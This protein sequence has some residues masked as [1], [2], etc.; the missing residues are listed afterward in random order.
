MTDPK[1]EHNSTDPAL[2]DTVADEEVAAP[3]DED[4]PSL[5]R[6]EASEAGPIQGAYPPIP[7]FGHSVERAVPRPPPPWDDGGGGG[8]GGRERDRRWRPSD[9]GD[10]PNLQDS[11]DGMAVRSG[12]TERLDLDDIYDRPEQ[13]VT[14]STAQYDPEAGRSNVAIKIQAVRQVVRSATSTPFGRLILT[15]PIALVGVTLVILAVTLQERWAIIGAVIVAPLGAWLLYARYQAWL[16]HKRYM[17]RLLESLGE[18]VSDFDPIS[19]DRRIRR[20][21]SA[22]R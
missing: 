15:I 11:R 17:Y 5:P 6:P 1:E 16:G 2:D 18:D 7:V 21:T 13:M 20:R 9:L 8:G 3:P 12:E 19:A 4:T 10:T 14:G 22:G